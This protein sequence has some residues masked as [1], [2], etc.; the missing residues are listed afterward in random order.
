MQDVQIA[1]VL[2][3][4]D[5]QAGAAPIDGCSQDVASSLQEAVDMIASHDY[6][7]LLLRGATTEYLMDA[8]GAIRGCGKGANLPVIALCDTDDEPSHDDCLVETLPAATP[9][10]TLQQKILQFAAINR[11]LTV[12][13]A[14]AQ[15]RRIEEL[16][17]YLYCA[18]HDLKSPL[19]TF[20]GYIN[21]LKRDLDA[22]RKDRLSRFANT[23]ERTAQRMR[24]VI[25]DML[26]LC[27]VGHVTR[28]IDEVNTDLLLQS[29]AADFQT[30][31]TEH[32]IRLEIPSDLP[33]VAASE[34]LLR[35]LFENLLSNAIKYGRGAPNPCIRIE[36]H[37]GDIEHCFCVRDNGPGIDARYHAK[38]FDL[39]HR[40]DRD[41]TNG[42]GI[43]LTLVKRIAECHGG[44][45]W[46]ESTCGQGAAFW[47][48]LPA[49]PQRAPQRD[50]A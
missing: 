42:T 6:N 32:N 43:G 36:Y 1:R 35:Q 33:V 26:E 16:E 8:V 11:Q 7:V 15:Q 46:L 48:A 29:I 2:T 12:L 22:G 10:A 4:E 3:I 13:P 9:A 17:H 31:L 23:I 40:L 24:N 39:F 45:A 27:R 19:M 25:D 28:H 18:T 5:E 38:V 47:F 34:Q 41:D 30:Q 20:V 14:A 21:H 44:R 49:K 50:A 37:G